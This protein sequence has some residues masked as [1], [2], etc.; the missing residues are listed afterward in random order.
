MRRA[1][2]GA[3]GGEGHGGCGV[4]GKRRFGREEGQE[5]RVWKE[6]PTRDIQLQVL[7]SDFRESESET[8]CVCCVCVIYS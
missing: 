8:G 3:L 7:L 2:V 1:G 6:L 4:G 5:R